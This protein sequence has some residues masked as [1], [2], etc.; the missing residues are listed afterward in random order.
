[1]NDWLKQYWFES[2]ICVVAAAI[3]V[4]CTVGA[5]ESRRAESAFMS[6]CQKHRAPYECTVLWRSGASDASMLRFEYRS[7]PVAKGPQ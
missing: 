5:H 3:G 1:M 2:L 7:E 4:E 6:D